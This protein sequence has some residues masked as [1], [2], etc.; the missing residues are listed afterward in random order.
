M[1][2]CAKFGNWCICINIKLFCFNV[3]GTILVIRPI[4][5]ERYELRHI[6]HV[7][8]WKVDGIKMILSYY[9]VKRNKFSIFVI[10]NGVNLGILCNAYN[11]GECLMCQRWVMENPMI[12]QKLMKHSNNKPLAMLSLSMLKIM[13]NIVRVV[14]KLRIF[15]KVWESMGIT[16]KIKCTTFL[17]LIWIL[18]WIMICRF[19]FFFSLCIWNCVFNNFWF[20]NICS[21]IFLFDVPIYVLYLGRICNE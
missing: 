5:G 9:L 2:M 6:A 4:E 11:I 7:S 14:L 16:M 17:I 1:V 3:N 21:C 13:F 18:I 12:K 8:M 19:H 10:P 20:F 15:Q